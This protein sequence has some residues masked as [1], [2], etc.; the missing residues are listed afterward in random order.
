MAN[1]R[2]EKTENVFILT[3]T[4]GENDNTFDIDTVAEFIAILDE[5]EASPGDASFLLTSNHEKTWCNGINLHWMMEQDENVINKFVFQ[6]EDLFIRVALLN[7]PTVACITGNAY[8]GGAITATGCDFRF[9]REDRGRFCFSEI[10]IKKAFTPA[11]F[12]L[13]KLLPDAQTLDELVL[14]GKAMGGTECLEKRVVHKALPKDELFS[15]SFDWAKELS[16]K[17]RKTYGQLKRG[18]RSEIVEMQRI[19]NDSV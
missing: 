11:M 17:D 13:V 9:M 2:L 8:A 14:T 4:N 1:Y 10:N 6:L 19:R 16:G 7:M 15:T 5:V 18:L 12:Q 3:M